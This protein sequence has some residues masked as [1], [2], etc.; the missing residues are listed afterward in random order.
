MIDTTQISLI[1]PYDE[2][3]PE[4]WSFE[5]EVHD[6]RMELPIAQPKPVHIAPLTIGLAAIATP[7]CYFIY[8]GLKDSMIVAGNGIVFVVIW[9]LAVLGPA[10]FWL[11]FPV[12]MLRPDHWLRFD[13]STGMLSIRGG[14][15][16]F[17]REEVVC[18]LSV[19][20]LRKGKRQTEFQVISGTPCAFEKH[21]VSNCRVLDPQQAFGSTIEALSEFSGIPCCYAIIDEN[22]KVEIKEGSVNATQLAAIGKC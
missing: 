6:N 4:R 14:W 13:R 1:V 17:Q 12:G 11:F 5:V 18:L 9:L 22:G 20:D 2:R 7:M 21:F 16:I 19:T 8:G 3:P 10:A 15:S